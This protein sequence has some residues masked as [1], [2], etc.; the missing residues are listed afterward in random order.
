VAEQTT[1]ARHSAGRPRLPALDLSIPWPG[2]GARAEILAA[3]LIT[4]L[5]AGFAGNS[6]LAQAASPASTLR[7]Y[8]VAQSR[9]D[10]DGMWGLMA[11]SPTPSPADLSLLSRADLKA[12]LQEPSNR[13]PV[14]AL[15][16]AVT[17]NP[18]TGDTVNVDAV[19]RS[20]SGLQRSTYRLRRHGQAGPYPRWV[21]LVAPSALLINLPAAAGDLSIDGQALAV[22]RAVAQAVA[23]FPGRHRV[24]I[25]A[26][27]LLEPDTE[28]VD[29]SDGTRALTVSFNENLTPAAEASARAR[30]HDLFAGCAGAT[31]LAPARCPQSH[32]NV[33]NAQ[34]IKWQ[35]LGDP[36][37]EA[38]FSGSSQL[39][40]AAG[41]FQM[42]L[43]Y[44]DSSVNGIEHVAVGGGF[45]ADFQLTADGP[46][47]AAIVAASSVPPLT[48]PPEV[49]DEAVKDVVRQAFAA[50]AAATSLAPPDC[51]YYKDTVSPYGSKFVN[52]TW[53]LNGDPLARAHVSFDTASGLFNVS[54]PFSMRVHYERVA[55]TNYQLQDSVDGT[56]AAAVIWNQGKPVMGGID[57]TS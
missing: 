44:F 42:L 54:G 22:K 20:P 7:A 14:G 29:A 50:C 57:R 55:I 2:S 17:G 36:A 40:T 37:G 4:A 23:V 32:T 18:D 38:T 33:T 27:A 15:T 39:L 51:P 21:V 13:I 48:R 16:T 1:R 34:D 35:L 25:A 52:V 11:L 46:N 6:Y 9:G 19:Y 53:S 56:F 8:L 5:I 49:T 3:I 47:T 28:L 24:S 43:S 12:M 26:S 30:L 41:H 10:A 31:A 45:R